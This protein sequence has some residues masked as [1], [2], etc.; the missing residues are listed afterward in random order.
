MSWSHKSSLAFGVFCY[1]PMSLNVYSGTCLCPRK[2]A[3]QYAWMWSMPFARG[4]GDGDAVLTWT[5]GV[6][7]GWSHGNVLGP[8]ITPAV[9][10]L[11]GLIPGITTLSTP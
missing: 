5:E 9:F 2:D 1:P 7:E 3:Q 6:G 8:V 4:T 10:P 11:P